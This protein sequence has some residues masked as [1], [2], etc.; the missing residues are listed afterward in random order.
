MRDIVLLGTVMQVISL[1]GVAWE[2]LYEG[3]VYPISVM[4]KC[5]RNGRPYYLA[6]IRCDGGK[7]VLER[8]RSVYSEQAAVNNAHRGF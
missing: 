2:L 8:G 6:Q 3:K 7:G 5:H 1:S 4:E